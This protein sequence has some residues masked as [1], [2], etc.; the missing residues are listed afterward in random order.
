MGFRPNEIGAMCGRMEGVNFSVV[1]HPLGLAVLCTYVRERDAS[2]LEALVETSEPE[3]S[4]K[5]VAKAIT[6]MFFFV[7]PEKKPPSWQITTKIE[8]Y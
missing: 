5:G 4:F 7:R 6:D 1:E 3:P 2:C 8:P